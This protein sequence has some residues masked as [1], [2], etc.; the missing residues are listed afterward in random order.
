M[1]SSKHIF[2]ELILNLQRHSS[3]ILGQPDFLLRWSKSSGSAGWRDTISEENMGI[4]VQRAKYSGHTKSLTSHVK[5][6]K[7]IED[8]ESLH[9]GLWWLAMQLF[10]TG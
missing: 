4:L 10:N 7:F 8:Y 3:Y 5:G 6:A 1:M 9:G 2:S